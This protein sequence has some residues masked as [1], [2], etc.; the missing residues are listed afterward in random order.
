MSRNS[1]PELRTYSSGGGSGSRLVMR[2]M[3]GSPT[4]PSATAARDRRVGGVEAAV[5]ADLERHAGRLDGGQRAVDLGEVERD[6]LLAEDRLARLRRRRRSGRRGSSV[7]VQIAT[8]S[9]S[10]RR[11]APRPSRRRD[12]Q[13]RRHL[14]RGRLV[15]VVDAR[16]RPRPAPGARAARRAC[17]RSARRRARRSAVSRWRSPSQSSRSDTTS[18]Q[19]PTR[20]IQQRGLHRDPLQRLREADLVRAL[21]DH[22]A[23][24]LEVLDDDQVL[25]AD[26]VRRAR[27]ERAVVGEAVAAVA[28]SCSP[29]RGRPCA[30]SGAAG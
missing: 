8:A 2:T 21:L 17:A 10:A 9:T 26:A 22:R 13:P 19:R 27:H 28:P 5:E 23:Q 1:P 20:P 18:S 7:G 30:G 15:G 4:V 14:A 29:T 3:C 25:E 24:V 16:S 12:A 6:R 11:S